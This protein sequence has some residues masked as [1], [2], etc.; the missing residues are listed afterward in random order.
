MRPPIIKLLV[1]A[2]AAFAWV[3]SPTPAVGAPVWAPAGVA[4]VHPGVQTY[5][6]GA[7]CTANFVFFDAADVYI[8]Q[9]AHC[10]STGANT[11]TNGCLT[12]SLPLGTAVDIDGASQP[13]TLAYNSWRAMQSAG[14]TNDGACLYNDFALV[15]LHP[16]DH[17]VVNPSVPH[18]G[19]PVA[20]DTNGLGIGEDLYSYGNSSLRFGVTLLS[21]KTGTNDAELGGGWGHATTMVSP[22]IPGDSG[23]A[24]LDSGGRAAGVLSTLGVSVP[25][26]FSN[27]WSDIAK[28]LAYAQSHGFAGVQ[29]AAGTEA[30]NGGKLP[31]HL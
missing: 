25:G 15:K 5:T 7:Q 17:D 6:A 16:A 24:L 19:G 8:G 2:L 13:G 11:E 20:V 30:F 9:A 1:A 29:L 4:T 31:L 3:I 23:S 26:G 27:N 18:W 12:P 22:G 21:P 28:A 14:E 10:S